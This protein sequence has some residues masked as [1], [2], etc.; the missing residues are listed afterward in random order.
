MS[1]RFVLISCLA[2]VS[3]ILFG[4]DTGVISGAILFIRGEFDLTSQTTGY[5]VSSVL[6]GALLG[7]LGSGR[8]ADYYGR[9]KLLLIDSLIFIVGTIAASL[10][11][12]VTILI[13]GRVVIG[14]AIGIASYTAPLYISEIAPSQH[15]GALV[16]L[17]QLAVACG[18]LLSYV[19]DWQLAVTEGWRLMFA[20]GIIPAIILMAGVF[21]L[22]ESPRWLANKKGLEACRDV[23][24][25]LRS[26]EALVE[27]EL[28]EISNSLDQPACRWT[29]LFSRQVRPT[30]WI[31][32]GLAL[33]QQVT[34]INTVLYYAPTIFT[35]AGF[36]NATSAILAT[37]GVGAVFVLFTAVSLPFIDRLGRKPLLFLGMSLMAAGVLTLSLQ[38]RDLQPKG[39][40]QALVVVG[41]L[42]YIIGFAISLGPIVWLMISEIFPLR[43]RGVGASIA[44]CCNWGA[45][46]IVALTFLPLLD[47][48][49]ASATFFLFFLIVIISMLFIHFFVPET[50]NIS[51]E[52]IEG[53]LHLGLPMR[54][55][56]K[57]SIAG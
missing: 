4:F 23:L 6:F 56:G 8:I 21:Y 26:N 53:N 34:G 37:M 12:S 15:R 47:S 5:V 48:I 7:A 38:F 14:I 54:E 2:A 46:G 52:Q 30:L 36:G 13:L 10:A 28:Q 35:L 49:G 17:N 16:S 1:K 44:T 40:S 31:G 20:A 18:I 43:V 32:I 11:P 41:M 29:T 9:K 3:G 33:I 45:N 22:P 50:K 25:R 19:V 57:K 27:Q 42:T 51:L 39:D 55:L 24:M